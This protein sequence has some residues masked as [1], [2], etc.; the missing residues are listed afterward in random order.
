MGSTNNADYWMKHHPTVHH[1]NVCA[2]FLTPEK[3]LELR[4]HKFNNSDINE[5]Q[6]G[7]IK[8]ISNLKFELLMLTMQ[9]RAEHQIFP[10]KNVL[11]KLMTIFSHNSIYL[12]HSSNQLLLRGQECLHIDSDNKI[13][14]KSPHCGHKRKANKRK[15][16]EGKP[17]QETPKVRTLQPTKLWLTMK[18]IQWSLRMRRIMS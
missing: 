1:C 15:N 10:W 14:K 9:S 13:H 12:P 18:R 17:G 3:L 2:E 8:M 6:T 4:A 16:K 11:I 7:M 5:N